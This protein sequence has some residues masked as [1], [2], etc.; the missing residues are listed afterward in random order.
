MMN[1]RRMRWAFL[2]HAWERTPYRVLVG[3]PEEITLKL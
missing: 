1:L 2:W 3:N